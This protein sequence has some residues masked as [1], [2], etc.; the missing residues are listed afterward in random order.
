[1]KS[2][3]HKYILQQLKAST[4]IS[5]LSIFALIGLLI[6]FLP[7]AILK[8]IDINSIFSFVFLLI[9]FGIPFGYFIGL[10]N[11]LHVLY[12]SRRCKR[13]E[14]LILVDCITGL[15]VSKK[16]RASE[17]DDSFCRILLRKYTNKTKKSISIETKVF[18]KIDKGDQCILIFVDIEKEPI[19]VFAG[20]DYVI[21]DELKDNIIHEF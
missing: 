9:V 18:K 11:I 10:R 12:L 13:K 1:M 8:T 14:Y 19:L 3:T 21:A 16:G 2:I 7:F 20:N 5:L 6:P 17:M 15:K 4:T